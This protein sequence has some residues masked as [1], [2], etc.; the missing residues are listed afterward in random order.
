MKVMAT[1]PD[2][3]KMVLAAMSAIQNLLYQKE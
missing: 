3:I 1:M 2:L